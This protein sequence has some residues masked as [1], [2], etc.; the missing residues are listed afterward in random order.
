MLAATDSVDEIR[1]QKGEREFRL[2]LDVERG[3]WLLPR[4]VFLLQEKL[5]A[6]ASFILD[7]QM[8]ELYPWANPADVRVIVRSR[9]QPPQ[10]ALRLLGLVREALEKDGPRLDFEQVP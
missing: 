10:D 8:R 9:G 2:Y 3:D 1:K 7:G 4:A 5:N 6:Y